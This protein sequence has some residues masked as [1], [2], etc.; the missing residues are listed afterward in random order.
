[1]FRPEATGCR[2]Y[3]MIFTWDS[4]SLCSS[5]WHSFQPPL[6]KGRWIWRSQRRRDCFCIVSLWPLSHFV[7]ALYT[8]LSLCDISPISGITFSING[9]QEPKSMSYW[10]KR[11]ISLCIGTM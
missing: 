9:K 3:G 11:S 5:E 2:H 8:I 10:A 4:S 1:L 7:T 6:C